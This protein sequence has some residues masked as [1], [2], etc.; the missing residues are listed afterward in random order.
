MLPDADGP[1]AEEHCREAWPRGCV[2]SRRTGTDARSAASRSPPASPS[3][4]GT[5]ADSPDLL[6]AADRAMYDAKKPAATGYSSPSHRGNCSQRVNRDSQRGIPPRAA[7][8]RM[9]DFRFAR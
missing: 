6:S 5:G 7:D 3:S 1:G 9:L 8:A 4:G 2:T